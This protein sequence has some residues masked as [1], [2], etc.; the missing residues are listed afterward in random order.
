MDRFVMDIR[1]YSEW[2]LRAWL[3]LTAAMAAT[4]AIDVLGDLHFGLGFVAAQGPLSNWTVTRLSVAIIWV[5]AGSAF[6]LISRTR[7]TPA[8]VLFFTCFYVIS[9]LY[10]NVLRERVGF[11]DVQ[12]YIAAAI[13][14]INRQPVPPRY[15]YPP[16]WATALS[17]FGSTDV[18]FVVCCYSGSRR[19][20]LS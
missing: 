18:M 12:D 3:G 8:R 1:R 14:I 10:A 19:V 4:A 5:L 6:L 9:F 11:G 7:L 16:L 15:L 17:W 13:A 2:L 20:R